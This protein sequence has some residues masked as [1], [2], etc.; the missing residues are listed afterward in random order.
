MNSHKQAINEIEHEY[1]EYTTQIQEQKGIITS[2][3]KN[4]INID[5]AIEN[6][7]ALLLDLG[8]TDFKIIKHEEEGLYRI[9]RGDQTEEEIFKSLSEGEKMIISFLYFT[10]QGRFKY[11]LRIY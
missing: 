8:I 1:K 2:E 10:E 6:I 9:T 4:V 7:N 3:Q 11:Q 5:E